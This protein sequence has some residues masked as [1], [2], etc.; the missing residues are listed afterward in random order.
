MPLI[1]P[2][3]INNNFFLFKKIFNLAVLGLSCGISTL[4][5]DLWD[6][7]PQPGIESRSPTLGVQFYPLDHQ[8]SPCY[9]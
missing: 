6:L 2:Y 3:K 1:T 4:N 9:S 8:G 5:C 7:T